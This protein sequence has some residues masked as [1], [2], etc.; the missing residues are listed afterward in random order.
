MKN[1]RIGCR[2]DTCRFNERGMSCGLE[3][4]EVK[5]SDGRGGTSPEDTLCASFKTKTD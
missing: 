2:V 4:I 3:S 5:P 1:Q